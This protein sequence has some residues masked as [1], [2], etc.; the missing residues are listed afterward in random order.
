[1]IE[2]TRLDE[3]NIVDIAKKYREYYNAHEGGCW[4][5]EKAY[6]RIHQIVTIEDSFCLIQL[7]NNKITG[8]AIGFFKEYDDLTAYYLEEI[9]IFAAYQ[10]KGYGKAF[11]AELEKKAKERGAEHMELVSMNDDLHMHFYTSCGMYAANNLKIMGKHF[12]A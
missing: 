5:F 4:T 10:N 2:Y 12:S 6:R 11:L 1:M 9:V 8:F 3:A 7:N